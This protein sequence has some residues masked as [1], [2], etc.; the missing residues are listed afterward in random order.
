MYVLNNKQY[1]IIMENSLARKEASFTSRIDL[2]SENNYFAKD[3]KLQKV[4]TPDKI[5]VR[6]IN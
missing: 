3:G 2:S 5:S 1:F 4:A 6:G